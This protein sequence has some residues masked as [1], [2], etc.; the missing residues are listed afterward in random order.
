MSRILAHFK[1]KPRPIQKKLLIEI[2]QN[3]KDTDVFVIQAPTGSGKSKLAMCIADWQFKVDVLTPTNM[4][5]EQYAKENPEFPKILKKALYPCCLKAHTKKHG[6]CERTKD[7]RRIYAFRRGLMNYYMYMSLYA[8][9][10]PTAPILVIDE[11]HNLIPTLQSLMAKKLWRHEWGWPE[12]LVNGKDLGN[13]ARQKLIKDPQNSLLTFIADQSLSDSPTYMFEKNR[14]Q[15]MRTKVPEWRDVI[16]MKPLEVSRGPS[17]YWG[18]HIKK[19]ILMSATISRKDIE[20]LGLDN[21]RVTYLHC[22]SPIPPKN[23]RVYFTPTVNI[24]H[25]KLDSGAKE[26]IQD[27]EKIYLPRHLGEKGVIHCTYEMANLLK[28]HNISNRLI[29]H[30]KF[31]KGTKY[32]EFLKSDPKEGKVLVASGLYEGIDLPGDLGRW[33][34]IAKVPWL[35]LADKAVAYKAETDPSWYVWSTL[36]DLIQACGRVCRGPTDVGVT[37]IVD[38]T[39]KTLYDKAKKF[40]LVPTWFQD[41]LVATEKDVS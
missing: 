18:S 12:E 16:L 27:L 22:D 26:I 2:E 32:Q 21:R 11:A 36:K 7:L 34:I 3:W 20:T 17:Y 19:L 8:R 41:A 24:T 40:D 33:Q 1:G 38:G 35:S 29:F 30:D 15:W 25:D 23:R 37:Y 14:E 31:N 10:R 6:N 4:L 9:K 28:S 13:W 5:V 39:F